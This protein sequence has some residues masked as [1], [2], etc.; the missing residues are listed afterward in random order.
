LVVRGLSLIDRRTGAHQS[1][2]LSPRADYRRIASGDVKVY[3]RTQ[4]PGRAWLVHGV[5]QVPDDATALARLSQPD[6]DPRANVVITGGGV[7]P[8]DGAKMA[9]VDAGER[10]EVMAY[11]AERIVL[12]AQASRP[13][14]L[15][16]A[17]AFYPG[18]GAA[19]DGRPVPIWRADLMLRAVPLRPGLH[20]VSLTYNP[21]SWRW[22]VTIS[23]ITLLAMIGCCIII[24]ILDIIIARGRPNA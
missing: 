10:I 21:A 22:G 11:D 2:T 6:F 8:G 4:A 1:I 18:W 15:V 14:W 23:G 3:E 20:E 16:L 5:E 17:D 12:R 9:R 24:S 7:V 13:G 19:V